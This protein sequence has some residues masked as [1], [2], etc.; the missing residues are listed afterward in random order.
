VPPDDQGTI[1]ADG[2]PVIA[3]ISTPGQI[4]LRSFS[5]T[6][7]QRISLEATNSTLGCGTGYMY[8]FKND[9][10][11]AVA[12]LNFC[13][14]QYIDALSLPENGT[15]WVLL[16]AVGAATGQA[17]LK[18]Y[19]VVDVTGTISGDGTP[20]VASITVPGQKVLLTFAGTANQ[21]VSLEASN[22]TNDCSAVMSIV[23]P[24]STLLVSQFVCS[25]LPATPPVIAP[26]NGTYTVTYDL[27]GS[28][29]GQATLRLYQWPSLTIGYSGK[30]RDKVGQGDTA[31]SSDGAMDGTFTVTV[32]SGGG[33]KTVNSLEMRNSVA[34]VWDT[35]PFNG[36]WALGA[37]NSLN[38]SLLNNA[39]S[40]VNFSVKAGATFYVFGSDFNNS[41]FN[42]GTTFLIG[43]KFT[44]GTRAAGTLTIP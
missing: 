23:K 43:V 25:G 41:H 8:I 14:G 37:A 13:N 35:K 30:I 12:S 18:L 4:I 21:V 1:T 26:V 16:D 6:Q 19:T 7:N 29:V 31:L 42:S 28:L 33:T 3:S 34:G 2:T 15:Y 24:D 36:S 32:P 5:G 22:F 39:D 9:L 10:T 17:T 27:P 11:T 40:S 44:D 38:G 20:T